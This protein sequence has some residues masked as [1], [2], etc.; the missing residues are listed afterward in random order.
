MT[1]LRHKLEYC[2]SNRKFGI[3]AVVEGLS[4]PASSKVEIRRWDCLGQCHIC[5][6]APFVLMDDHHVLQANSATELL[7][8]IQAYLLAKNMGDE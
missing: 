8:D 5:A 2:I 4:G 6:R 1:S 7:Q 3:H